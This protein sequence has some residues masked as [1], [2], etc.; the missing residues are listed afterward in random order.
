MRIETKKKEKNT[1]GG[2]TTC[3]WRMLRH[4]FGLSLVDSQFL[5]LSFCFQVASSG[6]HYRSGDAEVSGIPSADV[7]ENIARKISTVRIFVVSCI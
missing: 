2:L 1:Y 7:S 4:F 3:G 6:L 5:F